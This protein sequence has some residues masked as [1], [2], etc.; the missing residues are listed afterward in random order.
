MKYGKLGKSDLHVSSIGLGCMS[1]T[2]TDAENASIVSC[3]REMGINYFDTADL[4]ENGGNELKIGKLLKAGRDQ[5]ILA[6]KVGNQYRKDGTGWDW[7]PRRDYILAAVEDSLRRLQTDY[8]D[9]YQ[10][11]GGMETDPID[12]TIE[13]FERL[14]AQGKI[15]HYGI[16]SIRPNV[17]REYVKRSGIVSVMMQY[18][19]L[20]RR[21]E[22]DCFALLDQHQISV[23]SRGGLAQGLL[24]DK[25]AKAYLD[26]SAA[27]VASAAAA[28]REVAGAGKPAAAALRFVLQ[29]E[30][31]KSAVVGIRTIDQL[32]AVA[33]AIDA[34]PLSPR[35]LE[36]LSGAIRP[37]YYT[38]HR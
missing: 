13:A 5:V 27:E 29:P 4:Y 34:D 9:L 17:I 22:E 26:Y 8:I 10:L 12:E 36:K 1:L 23:L 6:T 15:R 14:K 24:L 18:S 21:P 3:A 35:E 31:V 38:S 25:P 32:K 37:G 11:H 2:G 7:N 33:G 19:L 20:D 30:V 16:S 28:I